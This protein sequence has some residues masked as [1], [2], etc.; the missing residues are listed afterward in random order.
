M[1]QNRVYRY[2]KRAFVTAVAAALA[3]AA[4][5]AAPVITPNFQPVLIDGSATAF[6]TAAGQ[7]TAFNVLYDGGVFHLWYRADLTTA[8]I[9]E[10]RH[11]TSVDGVNFTTVGGAFTFTSNPFPTG[12]PPDLYYEAVSKVAGVFKF[13]HW[14]GN[15]GAGTYPAYD[16]NNSVSDIGASAA[17]TAVTHR[18]AMTGGTAGQTAGSFGIVNGNWYGQCGLTGQEV[19]RSPYTDGTPP[20]VAAS[21][22]PSV[23][24]ASST[25]TTAGFPAGYINNHGDINVGAAGLDM[26]LTLRTDSSGARANKQVYYSNSLNDGVSW[27]AITPLISGTPL[28]SGVPFG[29]ANFAHPELVN[30]PA[31]YKLYVSGQNAAGNFV[32]AVAS[33]PVVVIAQ[34]AATVPTSGSVVLALSALLIALSAFWGMGRRRSQDRVA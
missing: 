21:I 14:T 26:V 19:C 17:N 3:S 31:G 28:L 6:A 16:Y 25:L 8:T 12:T 13:I 22:Y 10:L 5:M 30:G 1:F 4:A 9:G 33:A 15:G 32:I 18:G 2:S 23:L 7:G 27:S 29:A 34:P 24:N 20:G 11:A